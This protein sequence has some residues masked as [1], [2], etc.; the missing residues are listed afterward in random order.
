MSLSFF[1]FFFRE[2]AKVVKPSQEAND[3]PEVK[4]PKIDPNET[5][6]VKKVCFGSIFIVCDSSAELA[7]L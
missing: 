3:G 4:K 7:V 6:M 1:F 5:T 2:K